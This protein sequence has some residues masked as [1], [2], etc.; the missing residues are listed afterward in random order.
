MPNATITADTDQPADVLRDLAPEITLN[1]VVILYDIDN[2]RQFFIRQ[3]ISLCV[4]LDLG[5]GNH[6]A[7]RRRTNPVKITQRVFDTL[8]TGN[9][10]T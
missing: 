8:L 10:N 3:I 6:L 9:I 5:L 2:A 1:P 4:G 7:S